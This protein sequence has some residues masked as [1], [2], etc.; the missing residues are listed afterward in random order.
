MSVA[1]RIKKYL[2]DNGIKQTF[3]AEKA[4]IKVNSFNS[5]M[6]GNV[7]LSVENMEKICKAL[8]VP[9]DF[10]LEHDS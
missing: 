1:A 4:G 8:N 3:V 7:R 6:N 9:V 5:I 2:A 10:F